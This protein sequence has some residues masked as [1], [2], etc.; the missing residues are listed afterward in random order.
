[1]ERSIFMEGKAKEPLHQELVEAQKMLEG[2]TEA[3]GH[4]IKKFQLLIAND[5][6]FSQITDSFPYPIAIFTSQQT[7]TMVN[8]AFT[9]ET[10][11]KLTS[12]E[13]EDVRILP[14]KIDNI[15]L[16]EAVVQVFAGNT[17][18]LENLNGT[19]PMLLGIT[20]KDVPQKGNFNKAIVFP[21]SSDN[22]KIHGVIVFMP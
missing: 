9:A 8:K 20:S 13:K 11:I 4:M 22:N 12:L 7:L 6:L 3:H 16:A 19:L 14:Y 18:F 15:R 21:I 10:N 17:F 1:M 2:K 5:G